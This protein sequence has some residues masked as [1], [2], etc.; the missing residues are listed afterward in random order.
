MNF[1]PLLPKSFVDT[2]NLVADNGKLAIK[3]ASIP[4][5]EVIQ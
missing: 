5:M 3:T 2:D 4:I 1:Q